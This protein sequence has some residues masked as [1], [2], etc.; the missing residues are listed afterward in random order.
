M[1]RKQKYNLNKEYF[2]NIDSEDKAY[3]LGLLYADG[4]MVRTKCGHQISISLQEL[5]KGLLENIRDIV[6]PNKPLTYIKPQANRYSVNGQYRLVFSSK[7]MCDD[8]ER[9]GF[10][11]KASMPEIGSNL[12]PHFIRGYFDGDG[13]ISISSRGDCEFY[14]MAEMGL[15]S[16]F[17]EFIPVN[18]SDPRHVKA[19]MFKIRKSGRDNLNKIFKYLYTDASIFLERKYKKFGRL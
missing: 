16:S 14:I 18:F 9:L 1:G 4:T 15:L 7:E 19:N 6:V 3:L 8:L 5:D 17:K 13:C 10:S 11:N 2:K 12:I